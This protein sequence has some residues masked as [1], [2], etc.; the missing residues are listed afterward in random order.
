MTAHD[1]VNHPQHYTSHPSGIECIQVTEHM[2][3]CLGNAV[4]YI[5]RADLKHDAIEDLRKARWYLDREIAQREKAQAAV[6]T[7]PAIRTGPEWTVWTGGDQPVM[8]GTLVEVK[9]RDVTRL[10][11]IAR[12]LRWSHD[13]LATDIVAY[14]IIEA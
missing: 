9:R 12:T 1:S 2:G 13:G 14:R 7:A 4:K 10:S 3:F 11:R 8:D 5:W 6:L